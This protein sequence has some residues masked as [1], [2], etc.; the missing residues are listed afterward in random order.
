MNQACAAEYLVDLG[1]EDHGFKFVQQME[2][3]EIPMEVAELSQ[4]LN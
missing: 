1:D 2:V 3:E 4:N